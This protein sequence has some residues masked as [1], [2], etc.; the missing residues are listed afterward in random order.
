MTVEG[1]RAAGSGPRKDPWREAGA[2]RSH[3]GRKEE[4]SFCALR[5]CCRVW[6]CKNTH[7]M[8]PDFRNY[9]S[10]GRLKSRDG[11]AKEHRNNY[12]LENMLFTEAILMPNLLFS[13]QLCGDLM[14]TYI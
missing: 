1:R 7:G 3:H 12:E 4:S 10:R 6:L 11:S 9:S 2:K 5:G 14:A 13:S 8:A